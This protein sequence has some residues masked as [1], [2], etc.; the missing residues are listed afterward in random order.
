MKA[1]LNYYI[2]QNVCIIR[3]TIKENIVFSEDKDDE[4]DFNIQLFNQV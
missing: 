2:P 4:K 3:S 1:K